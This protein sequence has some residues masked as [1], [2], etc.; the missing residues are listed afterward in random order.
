MMINGTVGHGFEPMAEA[1]AENFKLDGEIGA[2]VCVFINGEIVVDL[3][4]GLAD[5][6]SGRAWDRDTPAPI[7]ST[8]KGAIAAACLLAASRDMFRLDEPVG[9]YW[10]AFSSR[11]KAMVTV[12]QILQHASG[13]IMFDCEIG[14]RETDDPNSMSRIIAKMTPAWSPGRLAGYQLATFGSLLSQLII[15]SDPGKR[16]LAE[17]FRDEVAAPLGLALGF[18]TSRLDVARRARLVPPGFAQWQD[19]VLRAPFALQRQMLNPFSRLHQALREIRLPSHDEWTDH[20]LPSG[21]AVGTARAVAALY[22]DL[23][24]LA[25][26]AWGCLPTLQRNCSLPRRRA[27]R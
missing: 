24:A 22:A 3:W 25:A 6:V 9:R 7:F 26:P 11:G 5:P 12:R 23:A 4:G 18:G 14:P 17:F 21:N 1:F 20:D 8:G 15:R 19:V 16:D 13:L 10:P 27:K 2:A